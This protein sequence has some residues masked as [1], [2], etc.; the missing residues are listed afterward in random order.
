MRGKKFNNTLGEKIISPPKE[1]LKFTINFKILDGK[2]SGK[3]HQNTGFLGCRVRVLFQ[4]LIGPDLAGSQTWI[5]GRQKQNWLYLKNWTKYRNRF[6]RSLISNILL[7]SWY[8]SQFEPR[9]KIPNF[10]HKFGKT[11]LAL[12]IEPNIE[13]EIRWIADFK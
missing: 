2:V 4:I 11:D 13:M 7:D 9:N 12:K 10:W 8:G 5:L 6:F 1:E 3:V